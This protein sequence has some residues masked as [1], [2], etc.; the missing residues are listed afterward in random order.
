MVAR[1]VANQLSTSLNQPVVVD[2]VVGGSG[3]VGMRKAARAAPDGYTLVMGTAGGGVI[4][5]STHK[6]APYELDKDFEPITMAA[7]LPF[8]LLVHPSVPAQNVSELLQLA[9][10]QPG[11]LTYVSLGVNSAPHLA[12]E[13]LAVPSDQARQRSATPPGS[14]ARSVTAQ[15]A[16][17]LRSRLRT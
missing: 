11:V 1:L 16:A 3:I 10:A 7:P 13:I 12:M 9:K 4:A 6:P 8:F 15:A 2:N 5:P 14:C 17:V